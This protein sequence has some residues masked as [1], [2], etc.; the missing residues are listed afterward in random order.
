[1]N[2]QETWRTSSYS[3]NNNECVEVAIGASQTRVRDTKARE[4]GTLTFGA[5]AFAGFLKSI[6]GGLLD[7]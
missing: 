3:G 6:D 4:A 1:M 5:Q 2:H 7:R